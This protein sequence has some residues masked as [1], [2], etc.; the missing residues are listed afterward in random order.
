[1]I[2]ERSIVVGAAALAALWL[3][4]MSGGAAA[5]PL[6]IPFAPTVD[7]SITDPDNPTK[8]FRMDFA[9]V[10]HEFPLSRVDLMK[11]T[12]EN[13]AALSQEQV[14]QIYGRLTAGPIPDGQYLGGLFFA[15]GEN[16]RSRLE[17]IVGGLEGRII[18]VNI[19]LLERVGALIWKGKEIKRDKLI[20]HNMIEDFAVLGVAVDNPDTVPKTTI[21]RDGP[22]RRFIPKDEVFLL[23]PA[24]IYCGQ[25]LLDARR[26][27]VIVDYSYNDEIEGYRKS[28]DFACRPRRAPHSRRNPNGPAWALSRPCLCE[29]RLPIKLH[30]LQCRC[31]RARRPGLRPRRARRGRLLAR[32]AAAHDRGAMITL[33]LPTRLGLATHNAF[34]TSSA[35]CAGSIRFSGLRS[36]RLFEN[37]R[38]AP[39]NGS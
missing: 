1:M 24:K 37:L 25:S 20:L 34:R 36:I 12:P 39:S 23:F 4:A 18:S 17:E 14:D 6:D 5:Q 33:P 10:E 27:S 19:G 3:A 30:A 38:Q 22:L 29:S 16:L 7:S 13:L 28:P 15:R 9:R 21:P 11:I 8:V 31:G 35:R 26:E 32:G 2:S